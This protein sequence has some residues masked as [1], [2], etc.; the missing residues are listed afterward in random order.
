MNRLE[1]FSSTAQSRT[2]QIT[3]PGV[4]SVD[5]SP[6]GSTVWAGSLTERI[7]A[8]DTSSLQ[9]RASY[10]VQSL[11]PIRNTIFD[12]PEE[13][14]V[15]SGGKYLL[16]L[17]QGAAPEAL[18]ALWDPANN[19]PI[20]LTPGE[21]QLF[22]NGLGTIARSGDGLRV[23]VAASDSSGELALFDS[24]GMLLPGRADWVPARYRCWPPMPTAQLFAVPLVSNGSTQ[25]Y[26]L[27]ASLNSVAGP[28]TTNATSLV[29]SR[30]GRMLYVAQAAALFAGHKCF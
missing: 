1:V 12:L 2:A 21:P 7:F 13:V 19:T 3:V 8:I 30:D 11:S 14:L 22:Q 5:L 17:R 26:L 9:V 18:L 15:L 29:F 28:L 25:L 10:T 6:D 16:R 27:D 24:T 20:D 23:L 4:S